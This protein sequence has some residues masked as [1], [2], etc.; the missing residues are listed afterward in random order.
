MG[1]LIWTLRR[2]RRVPHAAHVHVH[3]ALGDAREGAQER[4]RPGES[5]QEEPADGDRLSAAGSQ[6]VKRAPGRSWMECR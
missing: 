6:L 3:G 4:Q 2:L 1:G 5:A